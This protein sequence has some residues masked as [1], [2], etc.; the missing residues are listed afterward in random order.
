VLRGELE[1]AFARVV[2]RSAY[3]GG[4]EVEAF[5][6]EFAAYCGVRE[7]VGVSSGTAALRIALA[8]AGIG[9]G[10]EVIVPALTFAATAHA[11]VA[12]GAD[13]VFADV[14]EVTGLI[15]VASV[16]RLLS[17]RTAAIIPVHLYGQLCDMDAVEAI[18]ARRGIAILEDAAQAHGAA[19]GGRRAGSFGNAAGFSFYP[20]KNLGA[21]GDAGAICTSSAELAQRARRLR[22][23]GKDESGAHVEVGLNDRMDGLQAAFLRAKLPSLDGFNAAR[24]RHAGRYREALAAELS[25][26]PDAGESSVFHLFPIRWPR[27]DELADRLEA[28]GIAV[29]IHYSPALHQQPSLVAWGGSKDVAPVASNWAATELSLPIFPELTDRELDRIAAAANA[30]VSDREAVG[31]RA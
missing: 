13:P 31:A 27:R 30:A 6:A 29:Q 10:D 5:E 4:S 18:G 20:S 11:V 22:D 24:R 7:C 15:D 3:A 19:R 21:L 28:N 2:E 17:A 16:E 23:H 12:A 26:L 8:A 14:D 1:S 9:P 25:P